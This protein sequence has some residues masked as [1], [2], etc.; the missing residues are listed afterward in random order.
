M[1]V[2]ICVAA[3]Q[4]IEKK[5]AKGGTPKGNYLFWRDG[6]KMNIKLKKV[7]VNKIVYYYIMLK[8]RSYLK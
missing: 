5:I 7:Q 2:S 1:Q 8:F 6:K 4:K 3:L